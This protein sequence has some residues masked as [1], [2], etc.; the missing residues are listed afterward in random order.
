MTR[1]L[2]T[3][4]KKSV[5]MGEISDEFLSP[6]GFKG[7]TLQ[8]RSSALTRQPT[9]GIS[10]PAHTGLSVFLISLWQGTKL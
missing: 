9:L 1:E 8:N 6:I 3:I 2:K 4:N 5:R 10:P 7:P